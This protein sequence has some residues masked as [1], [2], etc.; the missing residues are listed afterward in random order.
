MAYTF[1]AR[2]F[3]YSSIETLVARTRRIYKKKADS[4]MV[5]TSALNRYV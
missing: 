5:R 3:T 1:G 2:R 4:I